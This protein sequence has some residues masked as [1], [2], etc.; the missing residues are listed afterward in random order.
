M[1]SYFIRSKIDP[2]L[3]WSVDGSNKVLAS[4]SQRSKFIVSFADSDKENSNNVMINS[5]WIKITLAFEACSCDKNIAVFQGSD[6][7]LVIQKTATNFR[8][9]DITKGGFEVEAVTTGK[10]D[11]K[12]IVKASNGE[13]WELVN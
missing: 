11:A 1:K 5:D 7:K 4:T 3:Y 9:R 10:S 12:A 13:R 2:T 6:G 8:F